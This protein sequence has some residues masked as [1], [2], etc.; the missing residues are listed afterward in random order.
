V[1]LLRLLLVGLVLVVPT[2]CQLEV[3]VG[4]DVEPDGSGVVRVAGVL[5]EAAA[6]RVPDLRDQLEVDDLVEAGWT[7]TGPALEADGRTWIRASK[8]FAAPEDAGPVL[9]E[10]SGSGGPFRDFAV[11]RTPSL[12]RDE[13]NVDGIVDLTAGLAGFSDDA[14]RERLDGTNVGRS[15]DEIAAEAGRSLDEVITF[16]VAVTVP[17][18]L[19]SNAPAGRTDVAEWRPVFGEQL[20]LAA[21]GTSLNTVTALWLALGLAAAVAL[22]VLLAVR[23]RRH[24]RSPGATGAPP[25]GTMSDGSPTIGAARSPADLDG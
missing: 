11:R 15:D 22:V 3:R 7:I 16:V 24:R 25:G 8:P 17:G 2:G 6:S 19:T 1:R 4:L 21:S 23:Y 13:W 18:E 12:L 14:L 5:D 10:I 9:D 20:A